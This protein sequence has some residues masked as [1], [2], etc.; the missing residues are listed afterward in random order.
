MPLLAAKDISKSFFATRALSNVNFTLEHGEIHVL[1][2]QNGAGKST[3]I[4]IISGAIRPHAGTIA[5]DGKDVVD[6]TPI[7]SKLLGITTIYQEFNLIPD[8]SVAENVFLG[9]LPTK[10]RWPYRVDWRRISKETSAFFEHLGIELDP[11]T[12]VRTLSIAKQQLVEIAKAL[13]VEAKIIILDE[14]TATLTRRE[15]S[16][17]FALLKKLKQQGIGIIYISHRLEEIEQ[18]GDRVT[19]LRD[20]KLVGTWNAADVSTDELI[21]SM[22]G[23]A[24]DSTGIDDIRQQRKF[25]DV[26]LEVKNLSDGRKIKDV[27]LQLRRGEIVGLGGLVGAGRTELARALFGADKIAKGELWINGRNI[28]SHSC[29]NSIELKVGFLPE[30]RKSEGL[31]LNFSIKNNIS[32]PSLKH[33]NRFGFLRRAAE[34]DA[35]REYIDRL[36]IKT[37]GANQ[38]V[39]LL[40]GGNQQKVVL[41]K[42]LQTNADILI[43]DEPT[44]GIDVA[45]KEEFYKIILE[46]AMRGAAVLLISSEIPELIRL[47]D[48]IVVMREGRI[49]DRLERSEFDPERLLSSA[50][51][52]SSLQ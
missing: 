11:N 24:V 44:R 20:G 41:A 29:R 37:I 16:S 3:L 28:T 32:L 8:L 6:L 43:F 34:R 31:L 49:A 1:L 2:G 26:L 5:V 46:C 17:L 25:D 18:I 19:V 4:K 22:V 10:K 35:A 42:W 40:S 12:T 23:H 48:R 14:P 47:S 30:D 51:G 45:A 27:D 36:Q 21:N 13:S 33:F 7:R 9:R 52:Q 38:E 50:F 15:I 39:R